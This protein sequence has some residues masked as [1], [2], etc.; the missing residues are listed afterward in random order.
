MAM[1]T[2]RDGTQLHVLDWRGDGLAAVLLHAWGLNSGMWDAQVVALRSAGYRVITLDRRG[3]GRSDVA[4]SGYD[5]A[6]LAAD[7]TAV[8]DRFELDQLVLVGHS[9]GGTEASRVAA[10]LGTR[11]RALVLSAPVT[12]CLTTSDDNAIGLPPASHAASRDVMRDG[13]GLWITNNTAG[14]WAADE[15]ALGLAVEAQWTRHT[16]VSTPLPV[17]LA[18]HETMVS[19]DVREDLRGLTCPALVIH[20]DADRSAPLQLTGLPTHALLAHGQLAVFEG[21]GHGLYTSYA[22]SYN[23]KLVEFLGGLS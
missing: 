1:I 22:S 15:S 19:A 16:V 23:H 3:H 13:L 21:A 8:V 5:L 11:V 2:T 7:V 14:Y 18:T 10:A 12:P 4:V 17:L 20:G 6:T 9:M